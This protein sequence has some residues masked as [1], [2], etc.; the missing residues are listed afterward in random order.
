MVEKSPFD[1][2]VRKSQKCKH[3]KIKKYFDKKY[4]TDERHGLLQYYRRP[5]MR[6]DLT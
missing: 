5:K 6:D 2:E 1:K 4:P 3:A